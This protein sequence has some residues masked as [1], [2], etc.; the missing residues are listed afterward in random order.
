MS[1]IEIVR[2]AELQKGESTPGIV[3][4]KAFETEEVLFARSK[5]AGAVKS[6]WH[7]H[8]KRHLYG[9]IVSGRLRFDYGDSGR[10]SVEVGSG[11]FFHIPV[12]LVHRDVNPDLNKDAVVVNILLGKGPAVVNVSGP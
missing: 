9:F 7:H 10:E 8:G 2:A 3:R 5:I 1:R 11:D 12:G 4:D 6:G